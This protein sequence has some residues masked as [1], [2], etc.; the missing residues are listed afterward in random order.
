MVNKPQCKL[1]THTHTPK[2][3][4]AHTKVEWWMWW[5][6]GDHKRLHVYGH[7]W[8]DTIAIVTSNHPQLCLRVSWTCS[9]SGHSACGRCD[10][11]VRSVTGVQ[12]PP[13]LWCHC[14]PPGEAPRSLCR[15]FCSSRIPR[16]RL[17]SPWW[18]YWGGG[19]GGKEA[20]REKKQAEQSEE[21]DRLESRK[22]G[23]QKRARFAFPTS[24]LKPT[25]WGERVM[26]FGASGC[27]AKTKRGWEYLGWAVCQKK[28]CKIWLCFYQKI[29]CKN[30]SSDIVRA[31]QISLTRI[32]LITP[33]LCWPAVLISAR[34]CQVDSEELDEV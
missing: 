3:T 18:F 12:H 21:K 22:K 32:C 27:I 5:D 20:E 33:W 29:W 6:E 8:R 2:K 26:Y 16:R 11:G 1:V 34:K 14:S 25:T 9:L 23:K 28:F 7:I 17:F 24:T 10:V 13:D 31:A 15:R 4:Q 30:W 19:S